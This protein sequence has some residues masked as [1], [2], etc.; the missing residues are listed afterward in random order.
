MTKFKGR[1]TLKQYMP[2][3]PVKR[4]IKMWVRCDSNTEYTYHFN[5]CSSKEVQKTD[6]TLAERVINNLT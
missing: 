1:S 2:L 4:G 5:I 3:K 6:G